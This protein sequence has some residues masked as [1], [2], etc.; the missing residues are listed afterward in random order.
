MALCNT[1]FTTAFIL[2]T[3]ATSIALAAGSQVDVSEPAPVRVG[4]SIPPPQKVKDVR[5]VYPPDAQRTGVQ[6]VVIIEATISTT[7]KVRD[8]VVKRSI[9]QLD[10][11]ALDAVKQWEFTPTIVEGTARPVIL[12]T[13]VNFT[14]QGPPSITP[15]MVFVASSR[16]QDGTMYTWEILQQRGNAQPT[17]DP[18]TMPTPP[19]SI[20]DATKVADAWLKQQAP[21][22]KTFVLTSLTLFRMQP[23]M[24]PD[25]WY[26]RLEFDPI[27]AG[28]RLSGAGNFVAVVLLDGSV[29][30]PRVDKR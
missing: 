30:E 24:W 29:V 6:G 15:G 22:L 26:Y 17:W 20:A 19:V 2:I 14:L 4:G 18:A 16:G 7:G 10:Q 28:R 27:V 1:R 8:A 3:L 21:E 25:R 9:P 11:A 5:P 23:Y 13:T 12:T